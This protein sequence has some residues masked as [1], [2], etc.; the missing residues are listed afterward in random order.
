MH[1]VAL[2]E[3]LADDRY[4]GQLGE[5]DW[6]VPRILI[7]YSVIGGKFTS[8]INNFEKIKQNILDSQGDEIATK[9][10]TKSPFRIPQEEEEST[11]QDDQPVYDPSNDFTL[12]MAYEE[13]RKNKLR[14]KNKFEGRIL[15]DSTKPEDTSK[16]KSTDELMKERALDMEKDKQIEELDSLIKKFNV[17]K[18][19][20][21]V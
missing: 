9:P 10:R 15:Y 20:R 4:D 3:S 19:K 11:I 17:D 18:V 13:T 14:G 21:K 2:Y 8:V 1:W 5:D 6:E 16:P 12:T 7:E